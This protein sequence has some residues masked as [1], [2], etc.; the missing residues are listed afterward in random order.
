M[1]TYIHK[2]IHQDV[3]I[4]VKNEK[5]QHEQK[6]RIKGTRHFHFMEYY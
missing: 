4:V 1:K 5:Q 3:I 2:N 6:Q